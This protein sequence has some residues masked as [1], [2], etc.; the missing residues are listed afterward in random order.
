MEQ[1]LCDKRKD[2][3]IN[4]KTQ[5]HLNQEERW[6]LFPYHTGSLERYRRQEELREFLPITSVISEKNETVFY[7]LRSMNCKKKKKLIN[8]NLTIRRLHW[9]VLTA[10]DSD[11]ITQQEEERLL[12]L[13]WQ[14]LRH[15]KPWAHCLL[16]TPLPR[17]PFLSKSSPSSAL[18]RDLYMALCACWPWIATLLI[19][20]KP[21]FSGEISN[22][23]FVL[24]QQN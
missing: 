15:E 9:A 5:E 2:L 1:E 10:S 21:I 3:E 24:G 12:L 17:L 7:K 20:N 11:N 6:Q 16:Q 13:P 8:R 19:L 22:N 23:L 18:C 14:G 4:G